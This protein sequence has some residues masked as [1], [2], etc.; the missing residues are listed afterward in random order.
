M[1]IVQS[2]MRGVCEQGVNAVS[3]RYLYNLDL[4]LYTFGQIGQRTMH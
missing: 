4:K 2:L 3:P 1:V